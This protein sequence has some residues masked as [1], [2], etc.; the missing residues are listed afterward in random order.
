MDF[1]FT[2]EQEM[3]RDAARKFLAAEYPASIARAAMDT[4]DAHDPAR[5]RALAELGWLGILVPADLGGQGGA[6]LDMAVVLEETGKAL[7]PGPFFASAVLATTALREA[8]TAAQREQLLPAL[9]A[10]E[11]VATVAIG[12]ADAPPGVTLG[13]DGRA[14][15]QVAFVMDWRS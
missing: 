4:V 3:L 10:G 7:V 13:A 2:P 8:G 12:I 5:W 1:G 14:T 6:F 9:A 11:R 15:G